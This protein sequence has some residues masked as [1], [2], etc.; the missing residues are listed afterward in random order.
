MVETT[1]LDECL[2]VRG[3]RLFV[4]ERDAV[5][6]LEEFGS[7]LFVLSEDQLRRNA[8]RFKDAFAAGWPDGPVRI[9]PAAKANWIVAAQRVLALEGCGCDVY[10]AGELAIAL[11]AGFEPARISVNGVPKTAAHVRR[12]VEAGVRLTVD[13]VE[14]AAFIE[15]AAAELGRKAI[16]RL[17]IKPVLAGFIERTDFVAEGLVPTDIA[18]IA[19][20]GGLSFEEAVT[21]GRR[22]LKARNVDIVGVH[23]H[24]GRHH[25]SL[26]YWE[27]QMRSFA[28]EIG[29]VSRAL[30]GWKP[31]EID[32]GGGFAVPRD[33]FNAATDYTEPLQL[34]AVYAIS[35][36]LR[37]LLPRLRYAVL[38]QLV[39]LIGSKPREERAP[40]IEQ[41]AAACTRTLR[42]EL[43][44][45]GI[46]LSGLELQV[47]PGRS[48][49][50]DA[51]IHLATVQAIKRS[52]GPIRWNT[53]VVDTTEFWFTGGRYEHHLHEFLFANK[54]TA[55]RTGK[56]DIIGRSCFGD[57]LMPLV[58]VPQVEVGDVL[59]IFDTGAY[60][61]VS[62][63]NFNAIPRPPTIL[64]TGDRAEVVR[65]RETDEDVRRRD[66]VPE[67]LA[68]PTS[69]RAFDGLL[70]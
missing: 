40:T 17:R 23:Q 13:S 3:G 66:R 62:M 20:K 7:P 4:E 26:R 68:L 59:A 32:I 22:L 54:A 42:A 2:S 60:Q 65:R 67:H 31:R 5:A 39:A 27:E 38:D 53:I 15:H 24:H 48:I 10:S 18:A 56:A 6:L 16:V 47:E 43:P 36:G 35:K 55:P 41:Y 45:H 57:R 12:C 46:D 70:N 14:E 33:P 50:A 30:G 44:R 51:G 61:E 25:A 58:R 29:R 64:V 49:H 52:V 28:A 21:V 63:S 11:A 19:Y 8:R 1:R 37:A 9:L 34:A 69:G